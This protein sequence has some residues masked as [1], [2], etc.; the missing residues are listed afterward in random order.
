[1]AN[2]RGEPNVGDPNLT[3]TGDHK[4]RHGVCNAASQL[5]LALQ[6]ADD[7]LLERK[8]GFVG[9]LGAWEWCRRIPIR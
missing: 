5:T 8:F 4:L 2:R 1:M 3:R 7:S 6:S 9:V